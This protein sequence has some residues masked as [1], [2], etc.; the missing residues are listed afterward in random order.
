MTPRAKS[1]I[2]IAV[3]ILAIALVGWQFVLPRVLPVMFY[4]HVMPGGKPAP[5]IDLAGPNAE[6][7]SLTDFEGEVVA[8][9]FGYTFCPDVCPTSLSKLARAMDILGEKADDVQVVMITVDPERDTPDIIA[10]YVAHF[11]P[12]FIGLTGDPGRINRIATMYGV[13]YEIGDRTSAAGYLINHTAAVRVIDKSGEL[14]LVLSHDL[15]DEQVAADLANL[16][17]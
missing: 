14:K 1:F 16:V 17:G 15:T 9:F 7:V 6:M 5:A 4:G 8:L 13:Y 10:K 11:H 3:G 2:T 12:S